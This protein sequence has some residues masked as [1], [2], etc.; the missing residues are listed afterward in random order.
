MNVQI[1]F[2]NLGQIYEVW[3]KTN[4]VCSVIRSRGS[5]PLI[6]V[7]G[8][9]SQALHKAWAY[10]FL[11]R[12]WAMPSADLCSQITLNSSLVQSKPFTS[13]TT[14]PQ[15]QACASCALAQGPQNTGGPQLGST[16]VHILVKK[17]SGL[18]QHYLCRSLL[19]LVRSSHTATATL[20]VPHL[21]ACIINKKKSH[22]L[23][24]SDW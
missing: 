23:D 11:A 4:L 2:Y 21:V 18:G 22:R 10:P 19:G 14:R 8:T 7:R 17:N 15:I 16:Y 20:Y 24:P 5:T 12:V 3:L 9:C 6:Q 1:L 13:S